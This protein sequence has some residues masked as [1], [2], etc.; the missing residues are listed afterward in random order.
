V[1]AYIKQVSPGGPADKAG[2]KPGD[3]V[4][5]ADG[6]VVQSFDQLT[7]IVQQH[8]PGD[9]ISVTYYRSGSAQ[10]ATTT[11]TLG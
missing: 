7:V 9:Q 2:L 11:V 6:Q 1:G 8:V 4:V 10:K 3:V 5:A